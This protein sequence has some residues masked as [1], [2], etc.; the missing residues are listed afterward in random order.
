MA[1]AALKQQ[2]ADATEA[3]L[4]GLSLPGGE[5]GWAR[6]ARQ[7]ALERV[8]TMGL[9]HR[10]DEYW[11]FT[12]PASLTRPEP[13]PAALF[14]AAETP[15]FDGVDRLRITFVDGVFDPGASDDLSLEGIEVDL[16]VIAGEDLS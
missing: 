6:D 16:L 10:R 2:K 9:P 15:L 5:A 14:D 8:R 13:I 7:A 3:R 12:D 11:K 4:A 1:R